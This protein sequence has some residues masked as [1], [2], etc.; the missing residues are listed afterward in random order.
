M[1]NYEQKE[2]FIRDYTNS[3]STASQ[4]VILFNTVAQ[5]ENEW[6]ADV[7]TRST[8]ELQPMIDKIIGLRTTA[9]CARLIVLREYV[10]WC[11]KQN[12]PQVNDGI[13]HVNTAAVE[14]I[15]AQMVANPAELQKYLNT[16]FAP[17]EKE[18]VECIYRC[19]FWL[20]YAGINEEDVFKINSE[21][22]DLGNMVINFN[23]KSFPIYKEAIPAFR[24]AINLK[25]FAYIHPNYNHV[26][27]KDR[28]PGNILLRTM[29]ASEVP[30]RKAFRTEM[31]RR[32]RKVV[33]MNE[34]RLSYERV[35]LSGLFYRVY[36]Q[37]ILEDVVDFMPIAEAQMCGKDYKLDSGR[38]TRNAK[39]RQIAQDYL[40]DYR[41]WKLAFVKI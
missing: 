2:A 8:A 39:A 25:Q 26:V 27:M 23:G 30:S 17:D 31:S 28:A 7:C 40:D 35:K 32:S 3:I 21:D 29:S 9:K 13:F 10:R 4:C 36:T 24:N 34:K 33:N 41:R 22:V 20:A 11:T 5:F 12:I 18:T 14:K 38:N 37:E 16:M 6:Q 15:K 19:Y 1:Y